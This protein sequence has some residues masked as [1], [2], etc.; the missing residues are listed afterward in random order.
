MAYT[1]YFKTEKNVGAKWNGWLWLETYINQSPNRKTIL[2]TTGSQHFERAWDSTTDIYCHKNAAPEPV[3]DGHIKT[4]VFD[5][6]EQEWS[7][8]AGYIHSFTSSSGIFTT[9]QDLS[10][11]PNWTVYWNARNTGVSPG[12]SGHFKVEV[13]KRNV[14]NK[15]TLLFASTHQGVLGIYSGIGYAM[16]MSPAGTVTTS[17]RLRIRVFMHEAIPV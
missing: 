6:V 2:L 13:H 3:T 9:N 8:S 5:E 1:G 17:D 14:S 7:G 16:T 12:Y 10:L 11:Q 4:T 15:D